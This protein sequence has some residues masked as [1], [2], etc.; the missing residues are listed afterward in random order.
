MLAY[1]LCISIFGAAIMLLFRIVSFMTKCK[2][3]SIDDLDRDGSLCNKLCI[4]TVNIRGIKSK[5]LEL[6]TIVELSRANVVIVNEVNLSRI[7]NYD[8]HIDGFKDYSVFR[9]PQRGYVGGGIIVY[10]DKLLTSDLV[11][12]HTGIFP[13]YE[14]LCVDIKT[15]SLGTLQ[16]VGIY[17]PPNLSKLAFCTNFRNLLNEIGRK[18]CVISGDWNFDILNVNDNSLDLFNNLMLEY[19]YVKTID[20]ATRFCPVNLMYTSS[21][22]NLWYNFTAKDVRSMIL[23]PPL[24]DHS[25]VLTLFDCKVK[26]KTKKLLFRDFS[27]INKERFL[28]NIPIESQN[29]DLDLHESVD[30][31]IE[32]FLVWNEYLLDKYFPR[33]TKSIVIRRE[34]KPW[35]SDDIVKL[36]RKKQKWFRWMRTGLITLGSFKQYALDLKKVLVFAERRYYYKKLTDCDKNPKKGWEIINELLGKSIDKET[37]TDFCINGVNTS[38]SKVIADSFNN[39]FVSIAPTVQQNIPPINVDFDGYS[40]IVDNVNSCFFYPCTRDEILK[41]VSGIKKTN[42]CFDL[43]TRLVKLSPDV[44]IYYVTELINLCFLRGV[45][46][47]ILKKSQITPVYK[48]GERDQIANYRPIAILK[49]LNKIFEKAILSRIRSFFARYDLVSDIQHGFRSGRSTET[50]LMQ[51]IS[52]LYPAFQEVDK[53]A[54]VIYLDFKSAFNCIDHD[55]LFA[56]LQRY[57]VR[58]VALDLLKSYMRDRPQQV[59]YNGVL[60]SEAVLNVG[61]GQGSC[62]GPEMYSIYT[63]DLNSYLE[64]TSSARLMFADDTNLVVVGNSLLQLEERAH[65]VLRKIEGWCSFNKLSLCA[66][67]TRA[68]LFTNRRVPIEDYPHVMLNGVR[69]EYVDCHTYLGLR[70][71]SKLKFDEQ[72]NHLNSRLSRQ[73]GVAYRLGPK[74]P[75]HTAR[76]LYYSMTYSIIKYCLTIYGGLLVGSSRGRGL[77]RLH[78]RIIVR[79]FS[80][81]F[82]NLSYDQML[83]RLRILKL[84]DLYLFT[85]GIVMYKFIMGNEY[86]FLNGCLD[87]GTGVHQYETRN[88][89][90]FRLPFPRV[91]A[92]RLNLKYQFLNCWNLIPEVIKLSPTIGRF[93][94]LYMGFL[95]SKYDNL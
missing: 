13:D 47:N 53:F 87:P 26:S 89:N 46:P 16:V 57:G 40:H 8:F 45:Y 90:L 76:T 12:E 27:L 58:G 48:R 28:V 43:C 56:K 24:S 61:I 50:A 34:R 20:L 75:L 86:V 82:R 93:K 68:T 32:K 52:T 15:D 18:K 65:E 92:V 42:K 60:S 10:V 91:E 55:I 74:I 70:I 23:T 44:F 77:E 9:D 62:L 81:H 83:C 3:I 67:K 94:R 37:Q 80:P 78:K 88:R 85:V 49:N 31:N 36:I 5:F 38:D 84:P 29:F 30:L 41:Y 59:S 64:N 2:Y 7:D 69:V 63:N 72:I 33:K 73:S 66:T 21:L 71:D 14:S 4:L 54:L 1:S 19:N 6:N 17:R 39:F 35:I 22:D 25:P 79:L 11:P 95:L 51:F